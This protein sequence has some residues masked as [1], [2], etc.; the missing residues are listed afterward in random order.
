MKEFKHKKEMLTSFRSMGADELANTIED[1]TK[2]LQ[3]LQ[4]KN[5]S[6]QLEDSAL[7]RKTKRNIARLHTILKDKQTAL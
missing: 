5:K 2:E 4:F 1:Y 3:Q 6:G 7:I